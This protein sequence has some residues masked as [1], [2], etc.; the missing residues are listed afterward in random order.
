MSV[1]HGSK[2]FECDVCHRNLSTKSSL[3]RHKRLKH[4][5]DNTIKEEGKYSDSEMFLDGENNNKNVFTNKAGWVEPDNKEEAD[6][7]STMEDIDNNAENMESDDN[8]SEESTE[9]NNK[10]LDDNNAENMESDNNES[11]ESTETNNKDLDYKH[12]LFDIAETSKDMCDR[13]KYCLSFATFRIHPPPVPIKCFNMYGKWLENLF[14]GILEYFAPKYSP[15]PEDF[16]S[17][18]VF[19]ADTGKSMWLW[20]R[21]REELNAG[22]VVSEILE[23]GM[24]GPSGDLTVALNCLGSEVACPTCG[25]TK[26]TKDGTVYSNQYNNMF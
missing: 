7:E 3:D 4:G 19:H 25:H 13:L 23:E 17:L 14:G 8:E 9:T 12:D 20:P 2:F 6:K 11:E 5:S 22:V 10:D 21:K 26:A 16:V 18:D 15:D 24:A 1:A